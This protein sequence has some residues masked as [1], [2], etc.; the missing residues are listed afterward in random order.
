MTKLR[1][2]TKL[3][4]ANQVGSIV[5]KERYEERDDLIASLLPD[6]CLAC[7]DPTLR[8]FLSTYF[9]AEGMGYVFIQP[10]RDT[11]SLTAM[12]REIAGGVCEFLDK[13]SKAR[14]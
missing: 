12:N 7:Y 5:T 10:S 1:E 2:R 3:L 14:L 6:P 13:Q 8:S 9:S 11:K 4:Y